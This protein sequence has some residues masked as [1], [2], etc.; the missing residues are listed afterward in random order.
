[1]YTPIRGTFGPHLGAL[2]V[3][4]GLV[5]G[6]WGGV[7]VQL[8][9]VIDNLYFSVYSYPPNFVLVLIQKFT[10]GKMIVNR[11]KFK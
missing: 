6:V 3:Q 4:L 9:M 11:K 8:N 2:G 10:L 1:M 5:N 7:Q